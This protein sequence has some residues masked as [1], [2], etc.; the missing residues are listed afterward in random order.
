M[1]G[2]PKAQN[3]A[4][5]ENESGGEYFEAATVAEEAHEAADEILE[6]PEVPDSEPHVP[7]TTRVKPKKKPSAISGRKFRKRDLVRIDD[8]RPSLADRIRADHPD[9]P[10]GA[11]VSRAELARYRMRYMEELLQQEHG[12]FSE[13][14][15]QVV[16]SIARQDTISENSEEEFEEHRSFADRVSDNMAEFGGSWWFLIS[17]AAVLLIWIG[18][19]LF[20]G[21]VGAFDPYPFILLNLMLSCIAAIQAPVIMMSQKRQEAKDRLRSFNDYRVNLKAELEVRHLH[22]KLDYLISRQWQRLAEMQQMQLD[23]MHELTAKKQKRAAR[24]VRRR[25]AKVE[26]EG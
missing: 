15:R 4:D 21:T 7:G 2:D 10:R 25:T 11:R 17:F 24:G 26:A 13:L 9:L 14:D 18:I 16:E 20:E 8:L 19:N 3:K 23:A 22:E 5:D 1:A 12:E 6:A